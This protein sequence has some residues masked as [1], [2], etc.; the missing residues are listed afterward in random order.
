MLHLRHVLILL[1]AQLFIIII[2]L[3]YTALFNVPFQTV[4]ACLGVKLAQVLISRWL[5]AVISASCNSCSYI[6]SGIDVIEF[7]YVDKLHSSKWLLSL[8]SQCLAIWEGFLS[9]STIFPFKWRHIVVFSWNPE[10][11]RLVTFLW[12]SVY[13]LLRHAQIC[14][15]SFSHLRGG[16]PAV[17][18]QPWLSRC[19][20]RLRHTPILCKVN[21]EKTCHWSC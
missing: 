21:S 20:D 13:L 16:H 17:C 1:E 9:L 5:R 11:C 8:S 3:L 18:P 7:K 2:T 6:S 19:S 12:A 14:T 15:E 4:A 10:K